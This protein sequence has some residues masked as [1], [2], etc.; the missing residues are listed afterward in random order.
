ML[1]KQIEEFQL[2]QKLKLENLFK[3]LSYFEETNIVGIVKFLFILEIFG[4]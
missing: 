3:D 4:Y 2:T 1:S